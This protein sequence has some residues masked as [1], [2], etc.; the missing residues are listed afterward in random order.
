MPRINLLPWREQ[1]RKVR[2]RE[3]GVAAGGAVFAAVIFTLGGKLLY[4]QWTDSQNEKNALLKK[5]IVKLDAQIA[6]IQ[7]LENR[8]QR[9]VARMEIIERLQRKRPEIVHL[10]DEIVKTVPEGVYLTNIKQTGNRLEIHGV[11]QSSTRVSTFMR[12]I[13][14]SVWMDNPVL[15]VVESSK[16]SSTGGSNFTLTSDVVG[17]DLEN[18]GE[19]TVKKV[20]AK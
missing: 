16:D 2:R 19:T 15:L 14:G 7:D 10:F 4:S 6:D 18:G 17:V 8:K 12:N 13:D 3:F 9:L 5:E 11:A 1:E 20:A